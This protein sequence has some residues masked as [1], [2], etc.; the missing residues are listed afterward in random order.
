MRRRS[1]GLRELRRRCEARL[2]ELT[3]PVPFDARA[4]CRTVA[5]KR[6]RPILLQPLAG[7]SGLWG[8]WVATETSDFIFYEESTTP[9]HQEHIILH[10]LSHLLC[11]HYGAAVPGGDHTRLLMPS[12]DPEMVRRMLGRTTY[13]AVEEQEAELLASL[14]RQRAGRPPGPGPSGP[15]SLLLNR[16]LA[17]LDWS[18]AGPPDQQH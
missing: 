11:D 12:L 14:I 17:A 3:L 5:D 7:R 2:D 16:L 18:Q 4:L 15:G 9:P 13:S 1:S 6:G 8:L 10:E